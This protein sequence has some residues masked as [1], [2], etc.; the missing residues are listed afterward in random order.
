[1]NIKESILNKFR[2]LYQRTQNNKLIYQINF[3]IL[4]NLNRDQKQFLQNLKNKYD[5]LNNYT[6]HE[7]LNLF[8]NYNLKRI[9][10]DYICYVDGC[11]NSRRVEGSIYKLTCKEH[12][13]IKIKLKLETRRKKFKAPENQEIQKEILGFLKEKNK[14]TDLGYYLKF[15]NNKIIIMK[16]IRYMSLRHPN[17]TQEIENYYNKIIK[18][19]NIIIYKN[20]KDKFI[21]KVFCYLYNY[22]PKCKSCNK[23]PRFNSG[24]YKK[25]CSNRCAMKDPEHHQNHIEKQRSKE[26]NK[27]RSK[28]LKISSEKMKENIKK[29]SL[30]KYGVKNP[31]QKHLKNLD[32]LNK[33]F[34]ENHFLTKDKNFLVNNFMEF[35][36]YKWDA[37]PYRYLK[38][39]NI[40][41]E[42]FQS[43]SRAEYEIIKFI[44]KIYSGKVLKN[45]RKIIKPKELDIYIPE[46]NLAIEFNGLY[47]HSFNQKELKNKFK[48]RH[49][50]KTKLA[51]EKGI[52][53]LHIFENEWLDP[54]KQDIWKS[55]ISYKLGIVKQRYYARKL[56]IKEISNK[57]AKI[58]LEENHIQGAIDS[59]INIG[60][61]DKN[62][63]ISLMTFGKSRFNK[64]YQYELYRFASKKYNSCVGCAQR[65]FKYFLRTYQP[66]S[67]IS[68]ANRRW[69]FAKSNVYQKIGFEFLRESEPNYYYFKPN[70][71]ILY[72]RN[73]FQKYKI[74]KFAQNLESEF[75][76]IFNNEKSESDLM[77]EAGYRR[78]Y[79]VG[80]LVYEYKV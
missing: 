11:N 66:K 58:F 16:S 29:T 57:E 3:H 18:E 4:K 65:L 75:Y 30:E 79:D 49:L 60:L 51:E 45:D 35:Y 54:I 63:L 22:I 48:Y 64:N 15:E 50:E 73:K 41:Y 34:I 28:S 1:M 47:W 70:E 52:N 55:I 53:L 59:K 80:Q 78:I 5:F 46:K 32:K 62:K 9:M 17:L 20:Q 23:E 76:K 43:T 7:I 61:F 44:E 69:A 72:P 13:N 25:Y 2:F 39:F 26:V 36:G 31:A 24:E 68:Y 38:K 19:N 77:F 33:E 71:L 56:I 67:I 21:K 14:N 10:N 74:R 6:D 42:K 37:Q 12:K 27:K 40:K 8:K